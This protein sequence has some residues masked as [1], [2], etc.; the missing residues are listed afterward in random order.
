MQHQNRGLPVER[1]TS[2]HIHQIYGE[3]TRRPYPDGYPEYVVTGRETSS[4]KPRRM[5]PLA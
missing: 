2:V 3:K 4:V 5:C 1:R